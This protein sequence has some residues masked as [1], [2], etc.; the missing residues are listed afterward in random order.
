M[1]QISTGLQWLKLT[2]RVRRKEKYDLVTISLF[3][4]NITFQNNLVHFLPEKESLP[5]NDK[6]YLQH[7]NLTH[8]LN[9]FRWNMI[10]HT[11]NIC[12]IYI[13]V[14]FFPSEVSLVLCYPYLHHYISRILP[15]SVSELLYL[16]LGLFQKDKQ[17]DVFYLSFLI[18]LAECGNVTLLY[19]M[20]RKTVQNKPS[21]I[22]DFHI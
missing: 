8:W 17:M 4:K 11:C 21:V 13:Y 15:V 6:V 7:T 9:T 3:S 20:K 12:N 5:G 10:R 1:L 19:K 22:S 18:S 14:G 2:C 16:I